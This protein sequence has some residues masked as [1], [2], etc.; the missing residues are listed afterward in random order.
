VSSINPRHEL[1][2]EKTLGA[3]AQLELDYRYSV[4]IAH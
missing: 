1:T 4:L 3:G 2:W